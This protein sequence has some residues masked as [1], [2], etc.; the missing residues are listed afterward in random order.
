MQQFDSYF[1]S[2][3]E[4]LGFSQDF[5]VKLVNTSPFINYNNIQA[6]TKFQGVLKDTQIFWQ[7]G[8]HAIVADFLEKGSSAK[9]LNDLDSK[10]L[11]QFD[12][13]G[14]YDI[15]F[16]S[17]EEY[18]AFLQLYALLVK[19][20][21]N[22][23]ILT[24]TNI[25]A[26]FQGLYRALYKAVGINNNVQDQ[27]K[28]GT[29]LLAKIMQIPLYSYISGVELRLNKLL[30]GHDFSIIFDLTQVFSKLILGG[31]DSISLPRVPEL[32]VVSLADLGLVDKTHMVFIKHNNKH[33]KLLDYLT[34]KKQM[35]YKQ[36]AIT[37]VSWLRDQ[38][39]DPTLMLAKIVVYRFIKAVKEKASDFEALNKQRVLVLE[40]L[41]TELGDILGT[42][43]EKYL[44][45]STDVYY[46]VVLKLPMHYAT[47]IYQD[48]SKNYVLT[49]F[50]KK[51]DKTA[52]IAFTP[53]FF[54]KE[55]DFEEV[56]DL[57]QDVI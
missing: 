18:S 29:N 54:A 4:Q 15:L 5:D 25:Y 50:I 30:Q 26:P 17:E 10:I 51:T 7:H 52:Y 27:T 57:L 44:L 12:L 41:H 33:E 23:K 6:S 39:R 34:N 8:Y 14:K 9:F 43:K 28:K 22:I 13:Y 35:F 2:Y 21:N 19:N 3:L 42:N 37:S 45:P 24:P 49:D 1:D 31:L 11:E 55:Y 48:L 36:E 47:R 53:S 20:T 16:L 40:K 46:N 56:L 32:F 38:L